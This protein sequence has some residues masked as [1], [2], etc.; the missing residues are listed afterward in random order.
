MALA[1]NTLYSEP[2][3]DELPLHLAIKPSLGGA[4]GRMHR[5][6]RQAINNLV[7]AK[8]VNESRWLVMMTLEKIGEGCTQQT[9]ANEL[10][11]EM[12][13]LTRTLNQ[14]EEQNLVE[15]RR[16]QSDR[17]VHCLWLTAKGRAMSDEINA[18]IQQV[19]SRIFSNLTDEQ[20]DS[21][22]QVLLTMEANVR[23]VIADGK[24]A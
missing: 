22:A 23:S 7:K 19:R 16:D 12:P 21:F 1:E 13:S 4:L 17:R 9:L 15:R 20:L 5:L 24:Q 6:W 14:L 11:I 3:S 10:C 18:T 2:Q 8:G